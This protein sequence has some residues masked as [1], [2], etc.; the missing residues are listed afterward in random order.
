M[1][2]ENRVPR[3]ELHIRPL[4]R[5]L[6]REHMLFQ[7]DVWNYDDVRSNATNIIAFLQAGTMP[8]P[9]YGGP[10]PKEWVDLL[11]R[12]TDAGF[13]RLELGRASEGGYQATRSGAQITL[14]AKGR[15]ASAGFKVWLDVKLAANRR[16]YELLQEP[17]MIALGGPDKPFTARDGF[18]TASAAIS[19]SVTD[20]AGRH[21]VPIAEG[22]FLRLT[23]SAGRVRDR[24]LKLGFSVGDDTIHLDGHTLTV[25]ADDLFTEVR[26][27]AET[28]DL[29]ADRAGLPRKPMGPPRK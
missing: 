28:L 4:M 17:P 6:D 5:L 2:G 23:G 24:L 21:D 1:A 14:V 29:F 25:D 12:W 27:P 3:F 7:F 16:E 26:G 13:P 15:V 10:W 19:L 9:A 11:R 18:E 20:A 8:P 22:T